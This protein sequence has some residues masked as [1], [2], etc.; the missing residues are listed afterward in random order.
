MGIACRQV[1]KTCRLIH[2]NREIEVDCGI[3][4]LV[5]LIWSR[6][7]EM[8]AACEGETTR[9]ELGFSSRPQAFLVLPCH[10]DMIR[11]LRL[12]AGESAAVQ[13][14]KNRLRSLNASAKV[15]HL[16]NGWKVRWTTLHNGRTIDFPPQEIPTI[17][18]RLV[19]SSEVVQA[20]R[21]AAI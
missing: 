17:L 7:I 18:E 6:G 14:G 20:G 12:A 4:D 15:M 19:R 21:V 5:R 1:N 10:E 9:M 11:F 2:N 3:A 16:K 8:E 13:A